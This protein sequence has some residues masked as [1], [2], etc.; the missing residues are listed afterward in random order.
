[1]PRYSYQATDE[2]HA[3]VQGE[4]EAS[5]ALDAIRQIEKQRLTL[6][7]IQAID[8]LS[9]APSASEL[10][11]NKEQRDAFY[12]RADASFKNRSVLITPLA[13][14]ADE[15]PA[16]VRKHEIRT[17][18]EQLKTGTTFSQLVEQRSLASWIPLLVAG[19]G[20][21]ST[22]RNIS[23]LIAEASRESDNRM[24]RIRVLAYP[25]FVLA[26]ALVVIATFAVTLFPTFRQMF[27]EFELSLPWP[28]EIVL[29]IG[30]AIRFHPLKTLFCSASILAIGFFLVRL[31][32]RFAL[33]TRLFGLFVSGNS[34][35]V[36]AMASFTGTLAEL[37]SIDAPVPEAV[38]IAGRG[39]R[40][41]HFEQ[42]SEL[43]AQEMERGLTHPARSRFAHNFPPNVIDA[44][45]G[46]GSSGPQIQ[47]LR[48]LSTLY[49]ERVQDRFG[50]AS[51][52]FAPFAVVVVGGVILFMVLALFMPL[53][54]LVTSL[55]GG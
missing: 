32:V 21:E 47:F 34:A 23:H 11:Q 48:E 31:W 50:L 55:G 43:L 1:M 25:C 20:A 3:V 18:I 13:A 40:H 27:D 41:L 28:T 45:L 38:R 49:A 42:M 54:N 17:L 2:S 19:V 53:L 29:R 9:R 51:W 6:L 7:S 30:D 24:R 36:N 39:C 16:G 10:V 26:I 52:L 14:L 37:L 44:L 33:T 35:N 15:M 12:R 5:N 8:E 22:T 4:I 46:T